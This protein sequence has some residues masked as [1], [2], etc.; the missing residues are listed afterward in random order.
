MMAT[1]RLSAHIATLV[2]INLSAKT[3][4]ALI[5]KQNQAK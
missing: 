4:R 2:T 3:N 1:I 5:G